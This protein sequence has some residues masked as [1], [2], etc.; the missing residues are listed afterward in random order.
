MKLKNILAGFMAA[1]LIVAG[2]A[3]APSGEAKAA[4]VSV[5]EGV[6]YEQRTVDGKIP[7][8]DGYFFGGWFEKGDGT[9]KALSSV[10]N[11]QTLYAKFVPAHVMS[12]K[13]QNLAGTTL[14]STST[15]TRFISAVDCADYQ[16]VGFVINTGNVA[17]EKEVDARKVY[18]KIYVTTSASST[19]YTPEGL[20]GAGA[21]YVT[22]LE[23][24]GIPNTAWDR[25]FYLRPYWVTK[26]GTQVYGHAKYVRVGD[27][28]GTD[29][30]ISVSLNLT[31]AKDVA[32]GLL[33]LKYDTSKLD[34]AGYVKGRVFDEVLANETVDGTVKCV[35]NVSD[36]TANGKAN[37]TYMGLRFK[38]T[39]TSYKLGQGKF[40]QFSISDVDFC[41]KD[42]NTV[43]MNVWNFQY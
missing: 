43:N 38:V 24:G 16:K 36:I 1:I 19:H 20:F 25:D 5:K 21:E 17:K 18:E 15:N 32:A 41:D 28:L 35:A 7:T 13:S 9:G 34:F 30:Y 33:T 11:G 42:E 23:M 12:V 26:D 3:I 40:L 29:K 6:Q 4:E 14:D 10:S 27:G 2:V 37:D 39:D 8:M 31:S 22:V